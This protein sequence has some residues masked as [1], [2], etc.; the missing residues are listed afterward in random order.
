MPVT[1]KASKKELFGWAMFDFANS[2]Y[3]T[4]IITVVFCVI[5]PKIIV[6][7]APDYRMGNLLWSVA[8]SISYLIV[9]VSAPFFG[10]V[11][12]FTGAKKK[13]LFG[14]CLLTVLASAA[15]FFVAPGDIILGIL[16][17]VLS[18]I[19]F[20]YSEAFVSSFLP[21]LGPP[22]SLGRISGYAWGLG[23][24]GGLLSTAIVVFGLG[25]GTVTLENFS[26]LRLVG[27]A[28]G[29]FFL[30]AAIPTFL[31]LKERSAPR[32]APPAAN[33]FRIGFN[34]LAGTMRDIGDYRDL[35]VLLASFFFAYAG[36][37]IVI[38]FAFIYG[39]QVVKW[40]A[41][42]QILM[43]VITQLTAAGGAFLFGLIQDRWGAKR[44]FILTLFL[45]I[46]AISLIYGVGG[47][48]RF[49]NDLTGT[50]LKEERV[51]LAIGSIAGLGLGSTQSACRAMVGLFSP[52][53]KAGEFFGLWSLAGRLSSIMGLMIIGLLQAV[54]GL[55]SAILICS[56][57]F[58]ISI[59]IAVAV[60]EKRGIAAAARHEGE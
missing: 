2:S 6:G 18:N 31:W 4:V 57:F 47:A 20:S 17:I 16:M 30:V 34:R 44:T 37:S 51:F 7:D 45:W 38:A 40:S 48:T 29:I 25:A 28:T 59:V 21:G 23:Y 14:S 19:G 43:F 24:F 56:L 13:F 9:L 1:A 52:A 55:Q 27:P 49:I 22:E 39:D 5:F 58:L 42:T 41:A 36:L 10:A 54:F 60:D 50:A 32:L 46:A 11:M 8:L 26:N 12:D 53:S 3:T 15:L 35:A 33:V